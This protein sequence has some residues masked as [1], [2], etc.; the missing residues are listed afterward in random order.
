MSFARVDHLMPLANSFGAPAPAPAFEPTHTPLALPPKLKPARP[1]R[2]WPWVL[3]AIVIVAAAAGWWQF[4]RPATTARTRFGGAPF[5]TAKVRR[6]AL[7]QVLRVAGVTSANQYVTLLTPQMQGSRRSHG[8][9]SFDL[10]LQELTPG[11]TQVKKGDVVATFDLQHMT[12]RLDDYRAWAL[13]HENNLKRL[14]ALLQVSRVNHEQQVLRA[15]AH[16]EKSAL[17]LKKIPI[18]SAIQGEKLRLTHEEYR[19][20]FKMLSENTQHVMISEGAAIRRSEADLRQT[21]IELERAE[22]NAET[23]SVRAP[24]SGITVML[25]TH[26]GHERVQI[27]AGDQLGPGERFMRIVDTGSMMVTAWVNQVDAQSVRMGVPASIHFDAYPD[28]ELPAHV[29]GVGS[30][31]QATGWR[32]SWVRHVAITLQIDELDKRVIPDLSVSADLTLDT[33]PVS[34]VVP[35]ECLFTAPGDTQPFVFVRHGE[36]WEKRPVET[37][38]QNNI[39]VAVTS[40]LREGEVLAAEWPGAVQ[41]AGQ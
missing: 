9:G 26:R 38:L 25:T 30:F 3:L 34:P 24:I 14:K 17:D 20:R 13:Q 33:A 15:R 2:R 32:P 31:A 11:G 28:L 21:R 36:G 18:V 35:R 40:G 4:R 29:V 10:T 7:E 27:S 1:P 8:R 41:Q 23:M 39:D 16:M 19:S 6:A 5:R 22:R 12:N 37:G